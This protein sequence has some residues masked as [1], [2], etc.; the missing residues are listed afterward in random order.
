MTQWYGLWWPHRQD[1][2][3]RYPL[4]S[5]HRYRPLFFPY[6]QDAAQP[7]RRRTDRKNYSRVHV[8]KYPR[9]ACTAIPEMCRGPRR[10]RECFWNLNREIWRENWL[11]KIYKEMPF[12]GKAGPISQD[13]T[14]LLLNKAWRPSLAV[15]GEKTR[16]KFV[17]RKGVVMTLSKGADGFPT[18]QS[19]GNVLRPFSAL[20]LSFRL[21]PNVVS[22]FTSL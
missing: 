12:V 6:R 21:P 10:P 7:C 22:L 2:P 13:L 9:K 3:R 4:W 14:E 20:K 18:L 1:S 16:R 17:L 11:A 19:A 15:T 8:H 5:C